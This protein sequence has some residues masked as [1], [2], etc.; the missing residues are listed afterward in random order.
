M[1]ANPDEPLFKAIRNGN[2]KQV[3]A[4]LKTGVDRA[5][6]NEALNLA[7]SGRNEAVVAR[8]LEAGADPNARI[9][10]ATLL[11]GAAMNGQL[12]IVKRLVAAG[13]DL[14]KKADGY[15]PF[16]AAASEHE[17]A[18]M[19][20]L[21]KAGAPYEPDVAL[22]YAAEHG[23]LP[24]ARRAIAA[25]ADVNAISGGTTK[26][27]PLLAAA[28]RGHL[29]MV[30]FLLAQGADPRKRVGDCAP[31]HAAASA[32]GAVG[33]IEALVAAGIDPDT[34]HYGETP[35]MRAAQRGDFAMARRL[36]ELGADPKARDPEREM[37]VVDYA[38][39]GKNKAL[40]S[41]IAGFG[42]TSAADRLRNVAAAIRK[43]YGGES[44]FHANGHWLKTRFLGYP[45]DI[46]IELND[47]EIGVH[48]IRLAAGFAPA[49]GIVAIGR[50]KPATTHRALKYRKLPHSGS[51][52]GLDVWTSAPRPGESAAA[53]ARLIK[54]VGGAV[55]SLATDAGDFVTFGARFAGLRWRDADPAKALGRL[56]QFE[57]LL[58]A[59]AR[60]AAP[61]RRLFEG[62]WQIKTGRTGAQP[63][64]G[65]VFGGTID[66]GVPCPHCEGAA[67]PVV[68]IDLR[69]PALPATPLGRQLLPIPWCLDCVEWGPD[70]FRIAEGALQPLDRSSPAPPKPPTPKLP[71]RA[72]ELV[73]LSPEKSAGRGSRLG[74]SPAWLQSDATPDCPRCEKPMAFALQLASDR[75]SFADEG[76]LY[77]FACPEC[78]VLGTLV[79]SH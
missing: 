4:A 77:A 23:D 58:T 8:L 40:R 36:V 65:H 27:T 45:C 73:P 9:S 79:Q 55:R 33:V 25:G 31:I 41:F 5:V 75:I 66:R 54:K 78:R 22:R 51:E 60:P 76:V 56:E 44:E 59:I 1:A 24:R 35:L 11:A 6:L 74:G 15:T 72:I 67:D 37:S 61:P 47:C 38:R 7:A 69:D 12:G 49:A 68:R 57:K 52:L 19:D 53:A 10:F 34:R 21:E 29:P 50:G 30:Q 26:E 17:V 16:S 62:G 70:F 3:D 20:Y 14:R 46:R 64:S 39:Q 43:K 28:G 2:L 32:D 71:A 18:V 48:G 63:D 13:A 42:E